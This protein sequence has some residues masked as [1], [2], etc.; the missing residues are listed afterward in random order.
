MIPEGLLSSRPEPLVFDLLNSGMSVEIPVT[1]DSMSPCIRS[2]DT[3]I[4]A[5]IGGRIRRGDVVAF[6]RPDGRMVIHRV[7][8]LAREKIQT[9][10]D[11]VS[12]AD[13]WI[14]RKSLIGR[15]LGVDRCGRQTRRGLGQGRSLIALL[16]R[17]GLLHLL[18]RPM[19]WWVR[20]KSRASQSS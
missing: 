8:A 17:A 12:H 10:G 16:S 7:V 3:L 14:D 9:R 1:G 19:R 5:P 11:A 4:L 18:L 15:V 20:I 13:A 2:S 6:P